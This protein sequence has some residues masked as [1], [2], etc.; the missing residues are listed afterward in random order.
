MTACAI[1]KHGHC[2]SYLESQAPNTKDT[3]HIRIPVKGMETISH[4]ESRRNGGGNAGGEQ[5]LVSVTSAGRPVGRSEESNNRK[6]AR[7]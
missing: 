6:T 1:A 2:P 4:R 7:S 3:S 5:E